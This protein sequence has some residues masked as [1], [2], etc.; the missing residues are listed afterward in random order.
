VHHH[1]LLLLNLSDHL[2]A[3]KSNADLTELFNPCSLVLKT[4]EHPVCESGLETEVVELNIPAYSDSLD[5]FVLSHC[6]HTQPGLSSE[7]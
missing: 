3:C 6:G 5:P 2:L 1:A 4:K 7:G